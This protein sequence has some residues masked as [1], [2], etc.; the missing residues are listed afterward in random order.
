M[1]TRNEAQR[2]FAWILD[3]EGKWD[4]EVHISNNHDLA[5]KVKLAGHET[6]KDKF[7]KNMNVF[8]AKSTALPPLNILGVDS[9][10]STAPP[11]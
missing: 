4:I 10:E 8:L 2:H 11:S 5:L 7:L 9:F 6:C 3:L 1:D